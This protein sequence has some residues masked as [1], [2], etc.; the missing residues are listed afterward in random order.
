MHIK[1][2]KLDKNDPFYFTLVERLNQKREEDLGSVELF[3]KKK[4]RRESSQRRQNTVVD[5]IETKIDSCTDLRKNKMLIEFNDY[6]SASV[7]SIAVK[8][9][10]SVK[11]TTRFMSG[12]LLMFAKL[13][14]KSFIYSLVELLSFPEENPIVAKIYAKYNI[15]QVLCYHVLT[16][17]YITSLRFII[18]FD[19]TSTYPNAM[20]AT[21]SS[22]YFCIYKFAIDLISPTNFGGNSAFTVAKIR[23]SW[24]CTK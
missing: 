23:K 14:L 24:V 4:K 3:A 9:Q 1:K 5:S 18:V 17:T 16:D 7:K 12:K 10:S 15:E 2:E 22:R 13:S 19:P 6:K 21:Y 11:C 20:F 8:S